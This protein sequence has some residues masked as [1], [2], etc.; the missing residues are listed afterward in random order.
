MLDNGCSLR[1]YCLCDAQSILICLVKIIPSCVS[2]KRGS[3]MHSA[4]NNHAL[5]LKIKLEVMVFIQRHLKSA[6]QHGFT[7]FGRLQVDTSR[8]WRVTSKMIGLFYEVYYQ[9]PIKCL[10]AAFMHI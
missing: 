7:V 8:N 6:E 4:K 10:S 5:C 1:K 3:A 9:M 2:C